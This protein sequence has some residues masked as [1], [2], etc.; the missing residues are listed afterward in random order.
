[1][2]DDRFTRRD[3]LRAAG[4]AAAL[5]A[6]GA[7]C[8]SGSE[9]GSA[10]A[11][12]HTATPKTEQALRIADWTH[13]VPA[14]DAWFDEQ[15]TKRWGERYGVDVV[16][17]RLP[18]AGIPDRAA[19]EIAAQD[20][21]DLVGYL[22]PLPAFEDHVIDHREIVEEAQGKL[23]KMVSLV[24]RSV[25]NPKTNKYFGFSDYWCANPV[26]YRVDLWD[27]VE[28]GMRPDTWDTVLRA[29]RALKANGHPLGLG[30]APELDSTWFLLS[31]MHA[32]GSSVQDEDGNL[33]INR[34]ATI[35]A[36]KLGAAIF[37]SGMTDEVFTWDGL[38][39]NR[40]LA[41]GSGSLILNGLSALR[42]VE[43]ENPELASNIGL[44]PLPAGP[45]GRVGPYHMVH[46][47]WIW[48]FSKNVETAKRFLVDLVLERSEAFTQSGFY[49]LPSFPATVPDLAERVANDTRA[50]PAGKYN[51]LVDAAAWS[52][53]LGHPGHANAAV[54]DIV[55]QFLVPKMF[56]AAARGE[57]S[58]ED[59]V[60][61]AEI[62]MAPIFEKWRQQGKI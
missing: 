8:R 10:A 26:H 34:P 13:F 22:A 45:S 54:D 23:G 20:G 4:G 14:Y 40:S 32:H 41:S 56:T 9:K 11:T 59:A 38:S 37:K 57:T 48:S 24:E 47:Y 5:V 15:Y 53:N 25:L 62:Q 51:L 29:G 50:K 42:A 18:Y 46:V 7:G 60:R 12:S 55:K 52:T 1:V 21:H 58:P 61:A 2:G 27:R 16:V 36:V 39:N 31:L 3:F 30:I 33:T 6:T 44:L 28:P 17:D 43:Q 49:A 19:T 35:E